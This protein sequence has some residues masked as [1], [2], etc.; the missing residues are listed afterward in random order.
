[1]PFCMNS[2][3]IKILIQRKITVH[4]EDKLEALKWDQFY[5]CDVD[6]FSEF[7]A[8][9]SSHRSLLRLGKVGMKASTC[10]VIFFFCR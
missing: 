2:K 6:A 9:K 4:V 8:I 1:M 10:F 5:K 7:Q 3:N